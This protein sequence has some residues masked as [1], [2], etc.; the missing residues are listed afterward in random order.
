MEYMQKFQVAAANCRQ[1][2]HEAKC[3]CTLVWYGIEYRLYIFIFFFF[4]L[5]KRK[6]VQ[7]D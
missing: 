6:F 5:Q 1:E 3:I 4:D 2:P 7:I